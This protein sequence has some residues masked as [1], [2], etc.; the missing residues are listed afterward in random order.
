MNQLWWQGS[1]FLF[2]LLFYTICEQHF[3]KFLTS[4]KELYLSFWI[5]VLLNLPFYFFISNKIVNEIL[6]SADR[7]KHLL[8]FF[9]FKY[10]FK[11]IQLNISFHMPLNQFLCQKMPIL[12][13]FLQIT[14]FALHCLLVSC[15]RVTIL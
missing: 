5:F 2:F 11:V 1:C 15:F 4:T 12:I 3:N 9:L 6:F 7:W 13:L 10:S 14:F 8:E